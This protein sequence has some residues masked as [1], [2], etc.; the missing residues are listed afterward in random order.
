MRRAVALTAAGLLA[1]CAAIG[2]KEF[3]CPGYPS[4]P[5]CQSAA[6]VY[7]ATETTD[8][9]SPKPEPADAPPT[10]H[11]PADGAQSGEGWPIVPSPGPAP[12]PGEESGSPAPPDADEAYATTGG[13][14]DPVPVA[15]DWTERP[16]AL[17]T[18]AGVMRIWIAPW[19]DAS[20][21]LHAPAYLYTE[22][23][24]RRW[25]VGEAAP[26]TPRV[27][28]PLQIEPRS[29]RAPAARP[30]AFARPT[31]LEREPRAR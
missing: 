28:A 1:G 19:E 18:P 12:L 22:I 10:G 20:G 16:A 3:S 7:A 6:E 11:P 31:P 2:E 13:A 14:V 25:R 23:E 4:E 30:D 15:V 17:R 29:E 27:L 5:L 21:N 8:R 24:P 9:V 26:T